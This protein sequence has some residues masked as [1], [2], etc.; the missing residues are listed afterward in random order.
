MMTPLGGRNGRRLAQTVVHIKNFF[1]DWRISRM[2]RPTRKGRRWR[3][4]RMSWKL[5]GAPLFRFDTGELHHFGPLR[6]LVHD[7]PGEIGGRARQHGAAKLKELG[8]DLGI[9][10]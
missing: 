4:E 10:E 3:V 8:V 2:V 6:D 1:L 5:A 9:G 7:L